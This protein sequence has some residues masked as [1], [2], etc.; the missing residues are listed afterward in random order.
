MT[1]TIA[2]EM[3]ANP[4]DV[5]DHYNFSSSYKGKDIVPIVPV[6]IQDNV[7]NQV[8][9]DALDNDATIYNQNIQT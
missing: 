4:Q 9:K 3:I 8:M 1:K 7:F 5:G 6:R 2:Q